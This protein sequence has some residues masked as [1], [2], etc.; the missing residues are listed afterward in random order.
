MKTAFARIV[1]NHDVGWRNA[2]SSATVEL[3]EQVFF[4]GDSPLLN[5]AP[6]NF[7]WRHELVDIVRINSMA[8]DPH[9]PSNDR[10]REDTWD[11]VDSTAAKLRQDRSSS[12]SSS[13]SA[14]PKPLLLLTHMPLHRPN[15][16]QCGDK[17]TSEGGGVTYKAPHEALIPDDEV[18]N[19]EASER[20]L[21]TLQ[22]DVV[23]SGHVHARCVQHH[24]I[25][26][27]VLGESAIAGGTRQSLPEITV[28]AFGWRMRPDASFA[29]ADLRVDQQR[30]TLVS[31]ELE[32]CPLPHEHVLYAVLALA[33]VAEC[34]LCLCLLFRRCRRQQQ[35][36]LHKG[37]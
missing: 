19:A 23:F 33:A 1:G 25:V 37:R 16:L 2:L 22:P 30:G 28:S 27:S 3:F 6:A 10:L 13:S 35:P 7:L 4:D 31:L 12:S 20:L 15:D 36:K 18:L 26:A 17:R 32:T 9:L 5:V 29:I 34:G 14:S 24:P 11:F 21:A 8:L